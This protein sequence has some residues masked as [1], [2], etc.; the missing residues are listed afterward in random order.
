[1]SELTTIP[2]KKST[3][4]RLKG[5]GLKGSTYDEI[6]NWLSDRVEYGK[7]MEHQYQRLKEKEKFTSLEEL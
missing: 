5:F 1:M 6:I 3:R 7:F 4:D 2:V